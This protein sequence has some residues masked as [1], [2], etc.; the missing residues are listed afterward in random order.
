LQGKA[1]RVIGLDLDEAVLTNPTLDE[2]HVIGVDQPFPLAD[3]SVDI[4]VSDFTFEHVTD[5]DHLAREIAR[6]L[7]PGGWLCART[8]NRFGYIGIPTRAI[9]NRLHDLVLARVQPD[10]QQRDTFPTH[11][12]LNSVRDLHR[13]FPE[14]A[15]EHCTYTAD[16]EPAY[17]GS[18]RA[19]WRIVRAAS[20]ITPRR[21]RSVMY[22]FLRRR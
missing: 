7:R 16:S 1:A 14:H 5:P 10:K 13:H 8:P 17:F 4:V 19:V 6:I 21:Y 2:A 11:Y 3:G 15:F 20:Q 18:S 12:R 22:V 9:P